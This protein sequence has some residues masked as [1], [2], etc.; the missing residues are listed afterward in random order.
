MKKHKD[1]YVA[2]AEKYTLSYQLNA[3]GKA[4][5]ETNQRGGGVMGKTVCHVLV[6]HRPALQRLQEDVEQA[7]TTYG[8]GKRF[9]RLARAFSIV[10][11]AA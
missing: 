8:L 10:E 4:T 5:R 3:S 1:I 2:V 9:L 11:N 6:W 7:C